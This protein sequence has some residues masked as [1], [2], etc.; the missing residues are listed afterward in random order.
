[1]ESVE[2]MIPNTSG[3]VKRTCYNTKN[4]K[5]ENKIP[6]I[7]GIVTIDALNKKPYRSKKK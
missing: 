2:K 5:I 3:M 7:N 6:S 1:M 4:T